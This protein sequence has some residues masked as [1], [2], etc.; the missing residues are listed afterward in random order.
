MTKLTETE[1]KELRL[2]SA[3][4][5]QNRDEEEQDSYSQL[6]ERYEEDGGPIEAL[7]PADQPFIDAVARVVCEIEGAEDRAY[8]GRSMYGAMCLGVALSS[9][10][11]AIKLGYWLGVGD[12]TERNSHYMDHISIDSMGRGVILYWPRVKLKKEE[13]L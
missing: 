4:T 1:M 13:K 8:S 6:L 7:T 10:D 3:M 2:L 9:S 5:V 12:S 11:D